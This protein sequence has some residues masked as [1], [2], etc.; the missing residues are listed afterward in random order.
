VEQFSKGLELPKVSAQEA[1]QCRGR[2][3]RCVVGGTWSE[4]PDFSVS[5]EAADSDSNLGTGGACLRACAST[6]RTRVI[7][8]V[9]RGL[10][11]SLLPSYLRPRSLWL[12][13]ELQGNYLIVRNCG[14]ERVR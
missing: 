10:P 5:A 9:G 12:A 8:V 7:P 3:L 13:I 14:M 1:V 11:T 6:D 2:E 4:R